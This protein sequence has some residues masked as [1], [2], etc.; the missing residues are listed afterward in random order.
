[1]IF[2]TNMDELSVRMQESMKMTGQGLDTTVHQPCPF[3][4]APDFLVHR[5]LDQAKM[6]E[7]STCNECGRSAKAIVTAVDGGQRI[8]IVQTGGPE[9]PKWLTPKLR[10]VDLKAERETKPVFAIVPCADGKPMI[11]MGLPRA[12]YR[13]IKDETKSLDFDFSRMGLPL[14]FSIFR[15]ETHDDCMAVLQR[16][17]FDAGTTIDDRR[18]EDSSIEGNLPKDGKIL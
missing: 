12:A 18:R 3:C 10:V 16:K 4:G 14:R 17:A 13:A 11:L 8:E 15:R 9:Q 5:L 6:T 7:N 2:P 1:M